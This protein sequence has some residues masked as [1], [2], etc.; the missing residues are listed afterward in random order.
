MSVYIEVDQNDVRRIQKKMKDLSKPPRHLRKAINRTAT[1]AMKMIRA[2][3]GQGYT[4]KA[5]RFNQDIKVYR[6]TADRLSAAIKS[7]GRPPTLSRSFKTSVPKSGGK[8]DVVK[9]GLK[10]VTGGGDGKAFVPA[11]GKVAG[12]MV[13]RTGKDRYPV[14]VLHGPS[15][16]KMV[17]KIYKGERG[18][19]GDMEDKVRKRLH[20]EIEKEIEKLI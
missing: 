14:K 18:G 20:E 16:P 4:V 12:L 15:V 19:Q 3:R 10:S 1:A 9:T 5:S 17:E 11:G 7:H 13:K 8:A 2:G 6:A